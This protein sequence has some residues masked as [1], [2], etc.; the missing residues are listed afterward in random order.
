MADLRALTAERLKE[1]C[2][3]NNRMIAEAL[4]AALETP[5]SPEP[6]EAVAWDPD[7]L[8]DDLSGPGL[9]AAIG[10]GEGALLVALPESYPL[11]EWYRRPTKS[12]NARLQTLAMELAPSL[13][14]PDV[15]P[16]ELRVIA[17]DGLRAALQA[18]VPNESAMVLPLTAAENPPLLIW[19]VRRPAALA[20]YD[21]II[22]A[23]A[24][25]PPARAGKPPAAAAG[26]NAAHELLLQTPVEVSVRLAEKRIELDHLLKLSPGSLIT[27]NKPCDDLLELYVN[28][29]RYALGEAVKIDENFGLKVFEV[30]VRP[31]REP[32]IIEG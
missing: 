1:L 2:A 10:A 6:G 4:Q 8:P 13:L 25:P 21:A 9:I 18:A 28:N 32:R 20:E 19:P 15:E 11:P 17:A 12:Q 16:G 30:G 7:A 24:A 3:Q 5:V 22:L 23:E 31:R 29:R 27:F 26:H 14:P